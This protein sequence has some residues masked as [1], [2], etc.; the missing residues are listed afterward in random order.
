MHLH[1][2]HS[3][4]QERHPGYVPVC[5]SLIITS[6]LFAVKTPPHLKSI[7]KSGSRA[8]EMLFNLNLKDA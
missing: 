5:A 4:N 1:D 7:L 8:S 2:H 3:L 6:V